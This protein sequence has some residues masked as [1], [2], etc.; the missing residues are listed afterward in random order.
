MSKLR[1][2]L[3]AVALVV[4]T[5]G[6]TATV[7]S[8]DT[9]GQEMTP[10]QSAQMEKWAAYMTP[11]KEHAWLAEKVGKWTAQVKFWEAADTE[12]SVST[13]TAEY[14]MLMDGRYLAEEWAG[15]IEDMGEFHAMGCTGFD[16]LTKKYVNVWID[17]LGTGIIRGEG[18]FNP[19]T[20]TLTWNAESP[21]FDKNTYKKV[22]ATE[23]II[24]ANNRIYEQ[25]DT[26]PD[27]KSFKN[28]E[29]TLTRSPK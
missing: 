27:G 14:E 17:N 20:K 10:E 23:R 18:T 25:W 21:D 11:G 12:P 4:S 13:V 16:N 15:G 2:T 24:D 28:M 8:Q 22:K 9:K 1:F 29:I 6:I 26:G 7:V 19:A 3:G 5:A